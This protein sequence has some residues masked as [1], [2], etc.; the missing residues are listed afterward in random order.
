M[1]RSTTDSTPELVNDLDL[2]VTTP[3]GASTWG[4][5]ILHPGQPDR[6]NNVEAVTIQ[7]ADG[8]Y[9]ITVSAPK[10]AQGPRQGYALVI[11]GDIASAAGRSRAARH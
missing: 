11:M 9:T 4:N 7:P 5:D 3:D 10:I 6:L 1:P 8:I 2:N